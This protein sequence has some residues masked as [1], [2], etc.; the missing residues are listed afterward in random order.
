MIGVAGQPC[1]VMSA[2]EML[3]DGWTSQSGASQPAMMTAGCL[4][5]GAETEP[6]SPG[7]GKLAAK[8]PSAAAAESD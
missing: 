1:H 6:R 5:L 4:L 2:R 7:W 3:N 8:P